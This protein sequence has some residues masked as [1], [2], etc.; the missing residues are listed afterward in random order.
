MLHKLLVSS[1]TSEIIHECQALRCGK[2]QDLAR[3][4]HSRTPKKQYGKASLQDSNDSNMTGLY[5]PVQKESF[6]LQSA[7]DAEI[8]MMVEC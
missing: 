1:L 8:E 6:N 7:A 5:T 3:P 2:S 4:S